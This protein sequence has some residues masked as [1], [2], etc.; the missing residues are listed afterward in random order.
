MVL[1]TQKRGWATSEVRR[2]RGATQGPCLIFVCCAQVG[3]WVGASMIKACWCWWRH[4]IKQRA[5]SGKGG[6]E[7]AAAG[8]LHRLI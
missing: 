6:V 4:D 3:I 8:E 1:G 7:R 5:G 2:Q